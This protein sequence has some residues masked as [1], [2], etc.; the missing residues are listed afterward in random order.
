VKRLTWPRRRPYLATL[1]VTRDVLSTLQTGRTGTTFDLTTIQR[2]KRRTPSAV[3]QGRP[4]TLKIWAWHDGYAWRHVV[5]ECLSQIEIWSC[6]LGGDG[7]W[8]VLCSFLVALAQ[9]SLAPLLAV[10]SG[11]AP[12]R[13]MIETGRQARGQECLA[14]LERGGWLQWV[15]SGICGKQARVRARVVI[16]EGAINTISVRQQVMTTGVW[17]ILGKERLGCAPVDFA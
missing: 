9:P 12:G 17:G 7:A 8:P 15:A 6:R 14:Y 4:Q 10:S 11:S 16:Q 13:A 5:F 1:D 2:R 3:P